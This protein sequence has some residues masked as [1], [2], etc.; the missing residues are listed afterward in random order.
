MRAEMARHKHPGGPIDAKLLRGGLVDL[1]FLVHY[2]QLRGQT[3]SGASL[4]ESV[5]HAL[6]PDLAVALEGLVEAELLPPDITG[7]HAL[8]SRMLVAGRLLAP[9]G[10][11][12]PPG[13]ARALAR[14]CTCASYADLLQ[15]FDAARQRVAEVWKQILG[16]DILDD[17]QE[18]TI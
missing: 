9:D 1:E 8:M 5:P 3:A 18:T 17:E 13:G 15:A 16:T 14:A 10:R 12:P 4:G 6:D 2:L 7:P 11:E